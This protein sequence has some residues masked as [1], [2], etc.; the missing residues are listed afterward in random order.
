[1]MTLHRMG[2]SVAISVAVGVS[3]AAWAD[4]PSPRQAGFHHCALVYDKR[5]RGAKQ[6]MPLAARM[7]GGRATR[8]LFDTFL[9]LVYSS[10]RRPDTLTGATIRSDWQYQLDRWFAPGRDLSAPDAAVD[11]AAT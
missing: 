5:V 4:Y 7:D 3:G 8:W 10:P 1:M 9:V 11:R 6:L 2:R